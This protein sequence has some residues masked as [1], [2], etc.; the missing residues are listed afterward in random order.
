MT[1]QEANAALTYARGLDTLV[2]NTEANLDTFINA[3]QHV[4]LDAAKLVISDYYGKHPNPDQR[5]PISAA[6]IRK[7]YRQGAT[8]YQARQKALAPPQRR[9]GAGPPRV[10]I[11][12]MQSL[13]LLTDRDPATYRD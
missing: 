10:F 13:G 6:H 3:L 9:K 7:L 11:E 4:P 12:R 8:V 5:K 2:P 1:P